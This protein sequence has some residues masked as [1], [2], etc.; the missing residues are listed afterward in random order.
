MS[1]VARRFVKPVGAWAAA[2]WLGLTLTTFQ[3]LNMTMVMA[4]A[5][6][7]YYGRVNSMMMLT[8]SSMPI[9]AT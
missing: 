1:S 4:V 5:D 7:Q 2:L 6:E 9:M 8:F 3:T